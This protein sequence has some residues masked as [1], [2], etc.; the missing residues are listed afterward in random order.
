MLCCAMLCSSR[1]GDSET[2]QP[3]RPQSQP[4]PAAEAAFFKRRR[5]YYSFL[6]CKTHRS[7]GGGG[8]NGGINSTRG[9]TRRGV[10]GTASL[11]SNVTQRTRQGE[12]AH[13]AGPI[14]GSRTPGEILACCSPA[15]CC[16]AAISCRDTSQCVSSSC[17]AEVPLVCR[18]CALC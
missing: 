18:R 17:P 5:R 13:A 10:K 15:V 4:Q 3:R 14:G 7:A 11:Q 9:Q 12:A 1:L 8:F 2:R 6:I 16:C